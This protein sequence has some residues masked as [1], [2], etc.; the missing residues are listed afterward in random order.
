M[1]T[2]LWSQGH[3]IA[4]DQSRAARIAKKCLNFRRVMTC[5]L[6]GFDRGIPGEAKADLVPVRVQWGAETSLDV[7]GGVC[8]ISPASII[9]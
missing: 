8:L 9:R 6:T 1:V 7:G 2:K 4:V 5:N 3:V